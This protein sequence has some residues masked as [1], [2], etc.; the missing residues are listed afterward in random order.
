[1]GKIMSLRLYFHHA[2]K[3]KRPSGWRSIFSP[4]LARH[5]LTHASKAGIEQAILHR[6]HA[7][8]LK[9]GRLRHHHI[10]AT[11]LQLPHCLELIDLESKLRRF[12][13]HQA[14][15]L[16]E[17]KAVFLPCEVHDVQGIR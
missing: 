16:G 15:H 6:V 13:A 17:V 5:L 11:H 4:T 10:D 14:D 7:G 9:G 1:M 2:A 12:L 3:T 8:Y